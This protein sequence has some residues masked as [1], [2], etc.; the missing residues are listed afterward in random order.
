MHLPRS[1]SGPPQRGR[2]EAG[3]RIVALRLHCVAIRS[4][5]RLIMEQAL[6]LLF[7]N[8]RSPHTLGKTTCPTINDTQ[9]VAR[10]FD[11]FSASRALLYI[12]RFAAAS[13]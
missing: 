9:F 3:F 10:Q 11:P 7:I 5:D 8:D 12:R 1:P 4:Q 13:P 6:A 2:A